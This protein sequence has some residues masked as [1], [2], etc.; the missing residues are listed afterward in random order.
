MRVGYDLFQTYFCNS[1]AGT[2]CVL[3]VLV[4]KCFAHDLLD[5]RGSK[6]VHS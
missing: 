1:S 2:L 6:G 5:L 4:R 3:D